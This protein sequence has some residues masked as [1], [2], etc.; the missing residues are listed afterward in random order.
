MLKI[1]YIPFG[2]GTGLEIRNE[3]DEH[4]FNLLPSYLLESQE[5]SGVP[6]MC[7]SSAYSTMPCQFTYDELLEAIHKLRVEKYDD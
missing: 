2:G 5:S 4:I 7:S 3:S 6:S 1:K